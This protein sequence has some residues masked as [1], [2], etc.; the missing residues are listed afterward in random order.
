[1]V[2]KKKHV[3]KKHDF[4]KI[5]FKKHDFEGK[6]IFKRH[7]FGKKIAHKKSRFASIYP[8]KCANCAFYVYI[9]KARF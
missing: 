7:D 5:G 1:M 4:K 2:L 6:Y 9:Q 8:V 3:F